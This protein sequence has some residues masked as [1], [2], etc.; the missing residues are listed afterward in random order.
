MKLLQGSSGGADEDND[1][2]LD[3]CNDFYIIMSMCVNPCVTRTVSGSVAVLC[4]SRSGL[5]AGS[6]PRFTEGST[7]V[8]LCM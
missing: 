5:L 6:R 3:N 7:N 1:I 2:N 4:Q 8:K